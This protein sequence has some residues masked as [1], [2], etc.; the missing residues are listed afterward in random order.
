[1]KG[2]SVTWNWASVWCRWSFISIISQRWVFTPRRLL[3][4]LRIAFS[5]S[6]PFFRKRKIGE[7]ARVRDNESSRMFISFLTT[8]KQCSCY[9][10]KA[11][12]RV[13]TDFN[14]FSLFVSFLYNKKYKH[15]THKSKQKKTTRERER[16][17]EGD[18]RGRATAK[19]NESFQLHENTCRYLR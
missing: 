7:F 1:M 8:Y 3:F 10:G 4:V 15:V 11:R 14:Y 6:L 12:T 19:T 9:V 2:K 16:V 13:S 18:Q 5:L 17:E